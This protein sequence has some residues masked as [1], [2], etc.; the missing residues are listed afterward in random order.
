MTR[1]IIAV[2]SPVVGLTML[3]GCVAA[4]AP[5]IAVV[6]PPV[7]VAAPPVVLVPTPEPV[8]VHV[9]RHHYAARTVHPVVRHHAVRRYTSVRTTYTTVWSP[10]CGSSAHPCTVEHTTAPIQ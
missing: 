10:G 7:A 1:Q 4:P 5:E 8:P 9:V 3:A 2:F 6:P